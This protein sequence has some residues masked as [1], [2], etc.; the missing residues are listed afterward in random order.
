MFVDY[1]DQL[2]VVIDLI[3]TSTPGQVTCYIFYAHHTVCM[4]VYTY[5][6]INIYMYIYIE[7]NAYYLK[8]YFYATSM[9]R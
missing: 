9:K 5:T 2:D 6:F 7:S 1:I 8:E 4:I 3:F